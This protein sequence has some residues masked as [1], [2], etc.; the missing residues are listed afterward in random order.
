MAEGFTDNNDV[1]YRISKC[2]ENSIDSEVQNIIDE[3]NLINNVL[4]Q[5]FSTC[6]VS[7]TNTELEFELANL[8][9]DSSTNDHTENPLASTTLK[10]IHT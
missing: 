2:D 9:S 1:E 7:I 3:Q 6:F 8:I 10:S 4:N 5:P